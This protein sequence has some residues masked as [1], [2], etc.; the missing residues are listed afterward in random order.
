MSKV[1]VFAMQDSQLGKHNMMI[2]IGPY[3]FHMD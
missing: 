3:D 1:E 2:L